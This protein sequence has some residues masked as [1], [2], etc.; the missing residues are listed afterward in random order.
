[1]SASSADGQCKGRKGVPIPATTSSIVVQRRQIIFT[2]P[3]FHLT[4]TIIYYDYYTTQYIFSTFLSLKLIDLS[5]LQ[6]RMTIEHPLSYQNDILSSLQDS[7]K[8]KKQLPYLN[9]GISRTSI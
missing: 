5:S 1:M 8:I 7:M 9:G 4:I 3:N 2:Y 6:D